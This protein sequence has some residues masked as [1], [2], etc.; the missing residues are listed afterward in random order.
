M[1]RHYF[2]TT[3]N[4]FKYPQ[5]LQ[6]ASTY[7]MWR[8]PSPLQ[9]Y[10]IRQLKLGSTQELPFRYWAKMGPLYNSYGYWLIKQYPGK[11]LQYYLLPNAAKYYAPPVEFLESY[12]TSQDT[13]AREAQNWFQYKTN[14]VFTRL[15]NNKVD[16]LNFLPILIGCLNALFVLSFVFFLMLKGFHFRRDISKYLWLTGSFWVVNFGFSVLASPVSLRFQVFPTLI[17]FAAT[18][19]MIDLIYSMAFKPTTLSD[20]ILTTI[21]NFTE[22]E[23]AKLV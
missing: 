12:N 16:I 17:F 6:F 10:G 18:S 7:Y 4:W 2:D 23:K 9:Q 1:A 14:K 15:K 20:N 21:D 8:L 19:L 5:E 11:Y 13:V 3:R 22:R